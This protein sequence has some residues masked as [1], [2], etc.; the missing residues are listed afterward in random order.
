MTDTPNVTFTERV[1]A[2]V[3]RRQVRAMAEMA[4]LRNPEVA[5]AKA[6]ADAA[7]GDFNTNLRR[8]INEG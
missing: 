6:D 3:A 7:P 2:V 5:A 4:A 1:R 8:Y